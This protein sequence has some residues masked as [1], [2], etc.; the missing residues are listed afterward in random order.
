MLTDDEFITSTATP[1]SPTTMEPPTVTHEP[2]DPSDS[3][4]DNE[5]DDDS[6]DK[7][8]L[9]PGVMTALWILLFFA[10]ILICPLIYKLVSRCCGST[11]T[12]KMNCYYKVISYELKCTAYSLC[13]PITLHIDVCTF[14]GYTV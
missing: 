9:K 1:A 7:N 5:K 14:T 6:D 8:V 4:D 11:D 2:S 10:I 13:C 12:S 3:D